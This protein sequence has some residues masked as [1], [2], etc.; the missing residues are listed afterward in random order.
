MKFL[1]R[2]FLPFKRLFFW[3][4]AVF[5]SV[6][7]DDAGTADRTGLKGVETRASCLDK[8]GLTNG[9]K[10]FIAPGLSMSKRHDSVNRKDELKFKLFKLHLRVMD[11]FKFIAKIL[12][13]HKHCHFWTK[14]NWSKKFKFELYLFRWNRDVTVKKNLI[15]F[16]PGVV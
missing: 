11:I 16:S 10:H 7:S 6:S 5:F 1:G 14:I 2:L 3:K 12:K 4:I 8:Q 13:H 9:L 15:C